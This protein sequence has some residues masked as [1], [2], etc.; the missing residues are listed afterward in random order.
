MKFKTLFPNGKRLPD[1]TNFEL[2][3]RIRKIKMESGW[4]S[5]TNTLEINSEQGYSSG[6]NAE[7]YAKV[8]RAKNNLMRT[9]EPI[10]K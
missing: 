7:H 9:I 5:N 10:I 8:L 2:I 1:Q 3:A 4:N 6:L